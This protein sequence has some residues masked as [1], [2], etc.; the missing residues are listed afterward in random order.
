MERG[1][2]SLLLYN[3]CLIISVWNTRT[4]Q[5]IQILSHLAVAQIHTMAQMDGLELLS[6][7]KVN[8]QTRSVPV[9]MLT[10]RD[11][12]EDMTR[13][14]TEGAAG[15][16]LKPVTADDLEDTINRVMPT[17]TLNRFKSPKPEENNVQCC[18]DSICF[19]TC[20]PHLAV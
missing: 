15:Y 3:K 12:L 16:I 2:Q 4:F 10:W 20:P 5:E 6:K 1:A 13:A 7:L 9:V 8:D 11:R 19:D 18:P 17:S 14:F